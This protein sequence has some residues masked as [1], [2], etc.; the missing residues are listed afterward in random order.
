[1]ACFKGVRE[2][3]CDSLLV[4]LNLL[5]FTSLT[6]SLSALS[7]FC[8]RYNSRNTNLIVLVR[9]QLELRQYRNSKNTLGKD[10]YVGHS[11]KV[12]FGLP[13]ATMLRHLE[14]IQS[15]CNVSIPRKARKVNLG[16]FLLTRA[17]GT[18]MFS[19]GN[20]MLLLCKKFIQLSY[21]STISQLSIP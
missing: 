8:R 16:N 17:N 12:V 9:K 11:E 7:V 2:I 15:L 1:M 18:I 3:I 14:K 6:A 10:R 13:F 5:L 19:S 4:Y 20:A 21:S